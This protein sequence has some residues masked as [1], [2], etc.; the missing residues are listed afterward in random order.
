M[1]DAYFLVGATA[2]GKSAV[3]QCLAER[4]GCGVLSADSMSIYCGM[5]IGTAKPGKAER[6]DVRY[7]GIDIVEPW[8]RFSVWE[9]RKH[10]LWALEQ[11]CDGGG[12][13]VAGGTGLYVKS[14]MQGL[15]A[16]VGE[17]AELRAEWAARVQAEGVGALQDYVRRVAP[18]AFAKLSDR[19]NPRRLVRVLELAAAGG[20]DRRDWERPAGGGRPVG[21]FMERELLL[22][23]IELRVKQMY[24]GGLLAEVERLLSGGFELSETA[25]QAIGYAEAI[26]CLKGELTQAEALERTV[27][28]TRRLAKRQMTWFRHQAEVDWVEVVAGAEV[29]SIADKVEELWGRNGAT[30]IRE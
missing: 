17:D 3:A 18:E 24:A 30:E 21:L 22:G 28:R 26:G 2:V 7:Y 13:I 4:R 10:A 25:R 14:L 11:E 27:I 19:E 15:R 16:E 5:D 1:M 20:D 9:Y 23:R 29:E 12:L 6:G 8:E